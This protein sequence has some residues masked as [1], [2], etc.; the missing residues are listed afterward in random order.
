[1]STFEP[2]LNILCQGS[3]SRMRIRTCIGYPFRLPVGPPGLCAGSVKLPTPIWKGRD[4]R[5][6][7]VWFQSSHQPSSLSRMFASTLT[8]SEEYPEYGTLGRLDHQDP[9]SGC[10]LLFEC[11]VRLLC[12]KV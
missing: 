5:C 11:C 1:M 6:D 2:T 8:K 12:S 4:R 3:K 9:Y 7:F 10:H